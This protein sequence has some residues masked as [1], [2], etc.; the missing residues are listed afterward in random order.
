VRLNDILEVSAAFILRIEDTVYHKNYRGI[1]ILNTCSKIYS[2]ILYIKLQSYAELFV[3]ETR[4]GFRK[5]LFGQSE[6]FASKY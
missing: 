6:G 2:K 1:S 4:R 5:A 3:T